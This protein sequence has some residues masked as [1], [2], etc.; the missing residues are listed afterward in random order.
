MSE[1]W[2][3]QSGPI[4]EPPP[5]PEQQARARARLRGPGTALAVVAGVVLVW[6]I[7]ALAGVPLALLDA[8]ELPPEMREA[9]AQASAELAMRLIGFAFS[10]LW[11]GVIGAGAWSMLKLKSWGLALAGAILALV[12]CSCCC[13]VSMPIGIWALVVLLDKDVRRSFA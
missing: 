7:L 10:L 11:L 12:P 5:T 13:I 2:S 9:F 1:S 4:V 3:S 6:E 8:V